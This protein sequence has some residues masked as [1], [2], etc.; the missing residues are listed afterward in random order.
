MTRKFIYIYVLHSLFK[1]GKTRTN[2]I[3]SLTYIC[4]CLKMTFV[5]AGEDGHPWSTL[6][7]L[8]LTSCLFWWHQLAQ[9]VKDLWGLELLLIVHCELIEGCEDS[10][11]IEL[12]SL[13][14]VVFSS[15]TIARKLMLGHAP[16]MTTLELGVRSAVSLST[17][18]SPIHIH[19]C[20]SLHELRGLSLLYHDVRL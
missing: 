18:S 9:T 6:S 20:E 16:V 19:F 3:I 8:N 2:S 1:V 4:D 11:H 12:P 7:H 15:C 14:S 10:L 17:T 5:S 13:V